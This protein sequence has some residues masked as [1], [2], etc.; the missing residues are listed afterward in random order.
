MPQ[1]MEIIQITTICLLDNWMVPTNKIQLKDSHSQQSNLLKSGKWTQSVE[2]WQRRVN[3]L[4]QRE[5]RET[6]D[7][8]YIIPA[9]LI[10]IQDLTLA[11]EVVMTP[12][13]A[14]LY[15]MTKPMTRTTMGTTTTWLTTK[16]KCTTM[17]SIL[18]MVPTPQFI[19]EAV[20][21]TLCRSSSLKST[22]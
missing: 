21:P 8:P 7:R 17:R 15:S 12:I 13:Q 19:V 6:Q 14:T 18:D 10:Q 3:T 1:L 16:D 2:W 20:S 11:L 5:A 9:H 4:L 22:L